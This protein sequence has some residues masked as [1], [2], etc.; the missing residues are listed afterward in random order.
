MVIGMLQKVI[1]VVLRISVVLF[2]LCGASVSITAE[3]T[4]A[5][6]Q[7]V[8]VSLPD[9]SSQS[10]DV[11]IAPD[12]S[13]NV[14]WLS[15]N[16]AAPKAAQIAA[17]G[18]SHDS[19]TNLYFARSVDGGKTYSMPLRINRTDGD[20]WGFA[21]SKPRIA[22]GPDGRIHILFPGNIYNPATGNTETLALYTRSDPTALKFEEPRRLNVD[23]LTDNIAKNDGGAFATVAV[24][25]S[26]TVYAAWVDTRTMSDGDAGRLAIAV[27]RDGGVVFTPDTIVLPDIVC[28]CCQLTSAI[29]AERRLLLGLRLI[30]HGY[31]DSEIVALNLKD[32]RVEWRRR[33][34]DTR[35]EINGCPRKPTAVAVRGKNLFAAYYSGAETPDGAY[36]THSTDSGVTWSIPTALHA[37]AT[38][39]DAPALAFAGDIVHAVWQARAGDGGFRLFTSRATSSSTQFSSPE[40]LPI[41]AGGSARLPAITA[42]QDGSLQ[43]VWQHDSS[44]R[45][46]RWNHALSGQPALLSPALR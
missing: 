14:V 16:T 26:N 3:L 34:T 40:A 18:H 27:S 11:A 32:Q 8:L 45:S 1:Y 33:V 19:K 13:I 36:V 46:L 12:G 23:S 22:V 9:S 42:H 20:V 7:S 17:R 30:E 37:S 15:D 43:I 10:P 31:R 39:S 5:H 41:P 6:D 35:W 2:G 4:T 28:P 29:D 24:D 25:V 44:I 21:I 38:R